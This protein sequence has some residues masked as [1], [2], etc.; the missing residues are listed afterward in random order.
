M[1]GLTEDMLDMDD[2]V[3]PNTQIKLSPF[4]APKPTPRVAPAAPTT[5]LS[6][7]VGS[8]PAPSSPNP[9]AKPPPR[10]LSS[11][12]PTPSPQKTT[13]K[14]EK[15]ETLLDKLEKKE[16]QE[17]KQH[18]VKIG[19][20]GKEEVRFR[21]LED[22]RDEKGNPPDHPDYDKSTLRIPNSE[23]IKLTPFERQYWDVKRKFFD[24]I[25]FFKKG[26]FY[27]LYE[28]DAD[29]AH[30]LLDLKVSE[31]V[32]MRMA[33][34]PETY[35]SQ[36]ASKLIA[37]GFKV[38]KVDELETGI[39]M[40]KRHN[41][42]GVAKAKDVVIRRELTCIL[43]AGTLT[44]PSLVPDSGS[45]YLLALKE[46]NN[47][48]GFV[49]VDASAGAV[50]LGQFEDDVRLS[51]LETLLLQT[52]AKEI[53]H[54]KGALSPQ[55]TSMIKRTLNKP[56][57]TPCESSTFCEPHETLRQLADGGY[58]PGG[59]FPDSFKAILHDLGGDQ[60]AD[61]CPL[62]LSAL[63][64]CVSYLQVL[65]LDRS[66][67]ST[68]AYSIY[69]VHGTKEDGNL[70]LDG[71]AIQNL[72]I[73]ANSTDGSTKGSLH[74]LLN[75]CTTSFGKRLFRTWVLK[76][77]CSVPAI[78]DRLDAVEDLLRIQGLMED[79]TKRLNALP[80]MERLVARTH[81]HSCRLNDFVNLLQAMEAVQAI[82]YEVFSDEM[83][84]EC[85]SQQ[86][87]EM[88]FPDLNAELEEMHNYFDWEDAKATARII[89]QEGLCPEYDQ[90]LCTY[91]TL[92]NLY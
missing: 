4:Q 50:Q 59:D 85:K 17:A 80:D 52:S 62:V 5:S 32:N 8:A 58:F 35:F 69:N 48:F 60:E 7:R 75:R 61:G 79:L 26:K 30:R 20:N 38:G 14:K 65:R 66:L 24:T 91:S 88:Q 45:H 55:V 37:Q 87:Q 34:V 57:F 81:S 83:R 51:T 42:E 89:P 73:L 6:Q 67:F 13:K 40:A 92:C 84:S 29:I 33:G 10:S 77:L 15:E 22:I 1:D 28:Q 72:E 47:V 21:F 16:E 39:G 36:W 43:T 53:L 23:Y 71:T 82:T 12:S 64:G 41:K 74:A 54:V 70:A 56:T 2:F 63:G 25:I 78:E 90:T 9:S 19:K 18:K 11:P 76:P 68:C 44:D 86:L 46:E 49:L 3:V 27:E 31:R